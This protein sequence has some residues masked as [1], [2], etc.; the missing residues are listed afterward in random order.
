MDKI[1]IIAPDTAEKLLQVTPAIRALKK[2]SGASE[3]HLLTRPEW[4]DFIDNNKYVDEVH[5]SSSLRESMAQMN[6]EGVTRVADFLQTDE[7]KALL[8]N[9]NVAVI[10]PKKGF[11]DGFLSL[12]KKPKTDAYSLAFASLAGLGISDD[13]S[14]LQYNLDKTAGLSADDLPTALSAGFICIVLPKEANNSDVNF[15]TGIKDFCSKIDHP[16]LLLGEAGVRALADNIA[17]LDTTK[18]YNAAGKFS[19]K[20]MAHIVD[21]SKVVIGAPGVW[22]SV[23]AALKKKIVLLKPDAKSKINPALWYDQIFLAQKPAKPYVHNI[24]LLPTGDA[25]GLVNE[26]KALIS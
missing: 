18:I 24:S 22:M 15:L 21:M 9:L 14:G 3:I 5:L 1:F 11:F 6:L 8:Q 26:V 17:A 7:S 25:S 19:L 10:G 4:K 2:A 13:R 20:E 16:V 12:F 23:A